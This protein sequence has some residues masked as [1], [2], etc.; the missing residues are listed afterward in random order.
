MFSESNCAPSLG[1]KNRRKIRLIKFRQKN[2]NVCIFPYKYRTAGDQF[3]LQ[4]CTE[5]VLFC[6]FIIDNSQNRL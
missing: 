1:G 2:R 6:S 3:Y 4:I 5:E